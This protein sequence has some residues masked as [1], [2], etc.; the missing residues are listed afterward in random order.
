MESRQESLE[1]P[2]Q[3]VRMRAW[4]PSGADLLLRGS[5]GE[6][7]PWLIEIVAKAIRSGHPNQHWCRIGHCLEPSLAFTQPFFSESPFCDIAVYGVIHDL[8][9][10]SRSDPKG[11]KGHVNLT[12]ILALTNRFDLPSPP[13]FHFLFLLS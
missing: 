4:D 10:G 7:E 3:I 8:L 2:W 12:P 13:L 6:L 11:E 1:A 5:A 9:A